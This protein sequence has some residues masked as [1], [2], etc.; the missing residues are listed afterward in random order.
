MRSSAERWN[1]AIK[2]FLLPKTADSNEQEARSYL[3]FPGVIEDGRR[4]AAMIPVRKE[5]Q[6][7]EIGP[8][9]GILTLPLAERARFVRTVE[10]CP[11]MAALLGERAEEA[12][13][14]NIETLPL[15]WEDYEDARIFDLVVCSLSLLLSDIETSLQKMNRLAARAVYIFWFDGE[16]RREREHR[17]L[18]PLHPPDIP[19]LPKLKEL[20]AVL[21][22]L[23]ISFDKRP[24]F[25]SGYP[26][27]FL[28]K[29][30]ILQ[31]IKNR[32]QLDSSADSFLE[33][34]LSEEYRE[35]GGRYQYRDQ[36]RFSLLF[37]QT[38]K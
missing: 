31:S 4:R 23:G 14:L 36:T 3:E 16:T 19:I 22:D 35:E 29:E 26:G 9:P 7:L 6:I 10:P 20:E 28:P 18:K 38:S 17:L 11:A 21:H 5:D 30:E 8:G 24:L 2:P 15:R 37:W 13:L 34:Y 25:D 32:H 27:S 33:R 1:R 12:G